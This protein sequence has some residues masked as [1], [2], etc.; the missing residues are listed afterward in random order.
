MLSV[1]PSV[2]NGSSPEVA[3]PRAGKSGSQLGTQAIGGHGEDAIV[4][5]CQGTNDR[6]G[7]ERIQR[8]G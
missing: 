4:H 5:A 1:R 3:R 6:Q 8:A 7:H 2:C